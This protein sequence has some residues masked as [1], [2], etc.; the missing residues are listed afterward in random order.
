V[1][2]D[3][4]GESG[5]TGRIIERASA[6]LAIAGGVLLLLVAVLVTASVLRR[7]LTSY[8]IPGDFEL[9]QIGL[10]IVVFAF[11]P[12]CQ[13]RSGNIFI[14]V[15]TIKAPLRLQ[16]AFDGVWALVYAVAAGL[17]AWQLAVGARETLA[18]KTMTMV[19]GLQFGWAIGL[20]A[21]LAAWLTLAILVSAA[22]ALRR[23]TA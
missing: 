11:L 13:L 3:G 15:F 10:A 1:A 2:R 22:R 18:S 7:W 21:A 14:D 6:G 23:P 12:F 9:V 4:T 5:R 8:A 16:A 17:I 20:C 19:L